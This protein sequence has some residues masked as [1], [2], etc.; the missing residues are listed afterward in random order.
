MHGII[1]LAVHAR[2]GARSSTNLDGRIQTRIDNAKESN[3]ERP[4]GDP[5]AHSGTALTQGGSSGFQHSA[6]L[7]QFPMDL[8]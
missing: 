8:A 3:K 7:S 1:Q 6:A 2:I 4:L 5:F